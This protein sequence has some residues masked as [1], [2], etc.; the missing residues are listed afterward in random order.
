MEYIKNKAEKL[1][2]KMYYITLQVMEGQKGVR[3]VKILA[4]E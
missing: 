3:N 4:K 2:D 1:P